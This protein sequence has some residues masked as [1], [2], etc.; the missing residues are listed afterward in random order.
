MGLPGCIFLK[1]KSGAGVRQCPI[2]KGT[3]NLFVI[4]LSLVSVTAEPRYPPP[5]DVAMKMAATAPT[6]M[7][8]VTNRTS[9][10]DTS[11]KVK[12]NNA[13]LN[14]TLNIVKSQEGQKDNPSY[15]TS[16]RTTVEPLVLKPLQGPIV[17]TSNETARKDVTFQKSALVVQRNKTDAVITK[18]NK[19]NVTA[20]KSTVKSLTTPPTNVTK[21]SSSFKKIVKNSS[22]TRANASFVPHVT[23]T[24]KAVVPTRSKTVNLTSSVPKHKNKTVSTTS[25][26][27]PM[28]KSV[29]PSQ[30]TMNRSTVA[31]STSKVAVINITSAV[32]LIINVSSTAVVK[33][34]TV[35][36]LNS[37]VIQLS[38]SPSFIVMNST[39]GPT[40]MNSTSSIMI[41]S[42]LPFSSFVCP[43]TTIYINCSTDMFTLSPS[44]HFSSVDI[45]SSNISSVDMTSVLLLHV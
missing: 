14:G 15:V 34:L 45:A 4:V 1:S 5:T 31:L 21:P 9:S 8:D 38:S 25:P 36:L 29:V 20:S 28:N 30:R 16:K 42:S 33:N 12:E 10:K 7:K 6:L 23:P 13:V 41:N 39:T 43:T 24:T 19:T 44:S 26:V 2:L 40:P 11:P 3:M 27:R 35:I 22:S 37:T 17:E 32:P 18:P